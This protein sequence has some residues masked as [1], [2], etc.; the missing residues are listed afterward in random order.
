M[1]IRWLLL[2]LIAWLIS[3]ALLTVVFGGTI[4]NTACFASKGPAGVEACRDLAEAI[5]DDLARLNANAQELEILG[6]P[7]SALQL[8]RVAVGYF[9]DN[10]RALQ[11]L[12]R[13]RANA[14]AR[15]IVVDLIPDPVEDSLCWTARWMEAL[16]ACMVE[17]AANPQ[18]ARL[19]ERLGDVARSVGNVAEAQAAYGRSLALVTDNPNLLRKREAL[20]ALLAGGEQGL[21]AAVETHRPPSPATN[22]VSSAKVAAAQPTVDVTAGDDADAV[23]R[24]QLLETLRTRNLI[25]PTEYDGRRAAIL[26][27]ALGSAP[28]AANNVPTYRG[29]HKGR[30]LA[31]VVGNDRYEQFPQ[32]ETAVADAQAV[33]KVLEQRYGFEVT[34]LLNADRYTVLSALSALRRDAGP[35][36]SILL[37]YA[38]HGHLDEEADRGYWLPVNAEPDNFARWISTADIAGVLAGASAKHALVIADSCFAGTLLRSANGLSIAALQRLAEKRSR[39]VLTSGGLEPVIDDGDGQH[40]VF[41]A[42]LLETLTTNAE[43]LEAGQLFV[44]VRDRVVASADQTPQ[45]AP[46]QKA[47]HDGGDFLFIPQTIGA[48]GVT[49]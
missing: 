46:M 31:V 25:S 23:R 7:D 30:Y 10:K 3:Q 9:P 26:S 47:G 38:G 14:R 28:V 22:T 19:Q 44:Q 5:G 43:V 13:A 20:A 6:R 24:L 1:N 48:F 21:P 35:E 12:I 33:S 2:V 4:N 11:G 17:A 15:R 32:L 49:Y 34:T 39:T 37:Y 41:A 8:Y 29:L 18:D 16:G 45:Y 40:S 36:D 42:A 27:Q